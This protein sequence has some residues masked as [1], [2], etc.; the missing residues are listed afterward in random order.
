MYEDGG[1]LFWPEND[2]A[3]DVMKDE[4]GWGSGRAMCGCELAWTCEG[5]PEFEFDRNSPGGTDNERLW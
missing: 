5:R 3:F 2:G 1:K 4:S